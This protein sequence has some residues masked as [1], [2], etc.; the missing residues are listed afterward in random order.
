MGRKL[1]LMFIF[2]CLG[3]LGVYGQGIGDR[4]RAGDSEGRITIRGKVV[5]PDGT[6]AQDVK[7]DIDNT[8]GAKSYYTDMD[9]MFQTGN[10]KAGNYTI[11]V[12]YPGL[13]TEREFLTIDRDSGLGQSYAVTLF[14]RVAGQKK[15]D[16]YSNNPLFKDV[17]K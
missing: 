4:N 9:G 14:L 2:M 3:A 6:P 5:M 11:S 1:Q 13:S 12:T 10:V 8:D 15:G 7:V 17:P 16:F